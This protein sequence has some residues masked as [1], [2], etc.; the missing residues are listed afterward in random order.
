ME[1]CI[2]ASKHD[3]EAIVLPG[4]CRPYRWIALYLLLP[5]ALLFLSAE[6]FAADCNNGDKLIIPTAI[7]PR[8]PAKARHFKDLVPK[9]WRIIKTIHH[10]F[11]DDG[12]ADVA[13]A[14]TESDP[15]KIIRNE[16][17]LGPDEFDSNPYAILVAQKQ[18]DLTYKTIAA[19]FSLIPRRMDPI[20]DQPYSGFKIKNGALH[21]SYHFWQSAGSWTTSSYTFIFKY[22]QDCMALIG[23]EYYSSHRA[24][25]EEERVSKNFITGEY[26]AS[27]Y[28]P[29]TERTKRHSRKMKNLKMV[30]LGSV[31]ESLR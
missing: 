16:C 15:G 9:N 23:S 2:L 19:D 26:L 27:E 25:L 30:C 10:D 22:K 6:V 24:S 1:E 13:L 11:D 8:I 18:K 3:Q 29:E 28:N 5:S 7:A 4:F 12:L 31:P 14:I 17:E 20:L 21:V